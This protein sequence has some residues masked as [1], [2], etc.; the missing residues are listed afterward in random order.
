MLD[1]F[2]FHILICKEIETVLEMEQEEGIFMA[3]NCIST[4]A[5]KSS[6]V[7]VKLERI[8][9]SL[10]PLLFRISYH[11]GHLGIERSLT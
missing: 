9:T 4:A 8:Y 1:A 2:V 6:V 10:V 7:V 11:K 5:E 3:H